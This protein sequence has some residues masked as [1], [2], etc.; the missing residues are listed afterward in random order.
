MFIYDR[1]D[2]ERLA[3]TSIVTARVAIWF[4]TYPELLDFEFTGDPSYRSLAENYFNATK[5]DFCSALDSNEITPIAD[6]DSSGI[7]QN[8]IRLYDIDKVFVFVAEVCDWAILNGYILPEVLKT[9]V[10]K[11][12]AS[13][14]DQADGTSPQHN[15]CAKENIETLVEGSLLEKVEIIERS[16]V[17]G[18]QHFS[19]EDEPNKK[20]QPAPLARGIAGAKGLW[21]ERDKIVEKGIQYM[22]TLVSQCGC[23]CRHDKLAKIAYECGNDNGSFESLDKPRYGL[24]KNF[25]TEAFKIVPDERQYGNDFDPSDPKKPNPNKSKKYDPDACKCTITDHINFRSKK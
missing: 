10:T 5:K 21:D 6:S 14:H 16:I 8:G 12:P 4:L 15:I 24:L 13:R 19:S 11:S 25:K 20:V 18:N 17:Q 2:Y 9:I 3:K 22:Q 23:L 7:T 1:P